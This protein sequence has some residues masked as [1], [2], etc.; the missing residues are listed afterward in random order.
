MIFNLGQQDAKLFFYKYLKNYL[1][2][3]DKHIIFAICKLET[4][5]PPPRCLPKF[6]AT[7]WT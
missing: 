5:A 7:D 4:R 3:I 6:S 2:N 1:H